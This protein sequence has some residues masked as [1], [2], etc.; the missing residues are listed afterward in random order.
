MREARKKKKV[1][2]NSLTSE[3]R[4]KSKIIIQEAQME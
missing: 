4:I 2:L 1:K 3:I